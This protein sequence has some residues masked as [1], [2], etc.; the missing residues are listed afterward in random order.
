MAA[1]KRTAGKKPKAN[2]AAKKTS[3][4]GRAPEM[5]LLIQAILKEHP[6]YRAKDI[7]A[8]VKKRG[9]TVTSNYV[10]K[11]LNEGKGGSS[12]VSKRNGSAS[13]S[14]GGTNDAKAAFTQA[15]QV[16][17]VTRARK[18]LDILAELEQA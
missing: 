2:G 16:L 17:G 10:Y 12:K 3:G 6:D 9:K 18:L 13:P 1:K 15:V 14:S 8:S 7:V 4:R 5:K 11:V